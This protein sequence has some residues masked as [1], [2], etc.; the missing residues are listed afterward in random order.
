MSDLFDKLKQG[1][2]GISN[3][4][5]QGK[6]GM[7]GAAG[8]GG[9]LGALFGG[10]KSVQRT[11]KNAAVIGGSAALAALAYK[12]YQNWSQGKQASQGQA[13]QGY[14]AGQGY[15]AP[16]GYG[17]ASG[18]FGAASSDNPFADY[19]AQQA[20][21]MLS[22]DTGKLVLKAMVFAARADGHID[23]SEQEVILSTAK[24]VTN[25][26]NFNQLIRDYLN[27]P[28]DPKSLAAQVS[29]REQALDLYRLS[30]AAIVADNQA[31]QNYLNALASALG[32]DGSTKLQL[33]QESA[34]LRL[35]LA[36]Q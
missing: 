11:A 16:Q 32:L 22:N 27:E 30:A 18:G 2:S 10:S 17:A 25:D 33:D 20:P 24:N 5:P 14:G 19:N 26:P 13:P 3:N 15:G 12:M 1:V 9:L 28:L 29:S 36:Q 7:L 21:A 34:Q 31:E 4:L 6:A 35:Q 8:V 23:P